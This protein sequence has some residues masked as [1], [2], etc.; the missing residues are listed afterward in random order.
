MPA[1]HRCGTSF[2]PLGQVSRQSACVKCNAWLRCCL[3]CEFYDPKSKN[4]CVEPQAEPIPDKTQSNFCEL[5][6]PSP[7]SGTRTAAKA[8]SPADDPFEKLFR[9]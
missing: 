8:A 1:C 4:E 2:D 5:F 6:R 7:K 3:N 9:K